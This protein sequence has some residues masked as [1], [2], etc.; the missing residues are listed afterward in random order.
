MKRGSFSVVCVRPGLVN[1]LFIPVGDPFGVNPKGGQFL[2]DPLAGTRIVGRN[3]LLPW[4]INRDGDLVMVE[5]F[6]L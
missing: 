5:E 6:L 4:C 3:F 1:S 2:D